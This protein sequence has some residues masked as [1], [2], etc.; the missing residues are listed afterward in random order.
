MKFRFYLVIIC[1]QLIGCSEIQRLTNNRIQ[2]VE[3]DNEVFKE[4]LADLYRDEYAPGIKA[5]YEK[6]QGEGK[7]EEFL[8]KER[9][10]LSYQMGTIAHV[11]FVF[12]HESWVD[13][14]LRSAYF[15]FFSKKCV[16]KDKNACRIAKELKAQDA[17]KK[18]C[19]EKNNGSACL[20]IAFSMKNNRDHILY[21]RYAELA[22]VRDKKTGCDILQDI[23]KEKLAAQEAAY[24]ERERYNQR[25][26]EAQMEANRINE[27]RRAASLEAI[28]NGLQQMQQNIQAQQN[29]Q[30]QNPNQTTCRTYPRYDIWGKYT[31]SETICK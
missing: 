12:N 2:Q 14:D 19:E 20:E 31:H 17:R 22:C 10:Y 24:N 8:S 3:D 29:S 5:T 28:G 21:E 30:V 7:F 11:I 4:E 26:F 6:K 27:V 15:E 1:F 9:D 16:E 23:A 13:Q 18:Q 25:R